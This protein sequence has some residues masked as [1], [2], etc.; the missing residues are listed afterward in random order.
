DATAD[1]AEDPSDFGGIDPKPGEP[2]DF[3]QRKLNS[4]LRRLEFSD[5]RN[6][7]RRTPAEIQD[8]ARRKFQTWDRESWVNP[9]LK[10]IT[11]V[12]VDTKL[13]AG[14]GDVLGVPQ[15]RLDQ[16]ISRFQ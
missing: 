16:H 7:R 10:S 3:T 15:R 2:L 8:H 13:A 5:G 14:L 6:A 4:V 12:R 1:I 11:R 9:T